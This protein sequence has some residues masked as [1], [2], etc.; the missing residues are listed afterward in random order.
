MLLQVNGPFA[1]HTLLG[2]SN[3]TDWTPLLIFTIT[4]QPVQ[5]I[6]SHAPNAV[7]QFYR[8]KLEP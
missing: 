1:R 3:L 4:G 7:R 5:I 8:L 2:S 6:D